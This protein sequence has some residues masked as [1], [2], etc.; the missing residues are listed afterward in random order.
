MPAAF[1]LFSNAFL[2]KVI[3]SLGKRRSFV[4]GETAGKQAKTDQGDGK[5]TPAEEGR[6]NLGDEKHRQ[7]QAKAQKD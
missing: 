7:N 3:E 2:A 6:N 4:I 1:I 5:N